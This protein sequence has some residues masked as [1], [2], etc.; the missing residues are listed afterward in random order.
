MPEFIRIDR[1]GAV[2]VVT[3]DRPAVLN[4]WH[5]AMRAEVSVALEAAEADASVRA[6]VLTG[7]GERAFCAGQDLAEAQHFA[8]EHAAGWI[9]EWARL[10]GAMR[11]L[12][13]PSLVALNG[14]AAG[15]GFQFALL[16]DVRVGHPGVRMGQ[17]E[18]DAG[19]PSITGPWIMQLALGHSRTVEL[20]LSARLMDGEEA[21]RLGLIHHLVPA[22]AVMG[23]AME[24]AQ[25]LAAK[26]PLAMRLTKQRFR[27]VTEAGFREALAAA[28]LYHAEGYASGEPARVMAAFLARRNARGGKGTS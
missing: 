16:A 13:K 26:P 22:E 24:V 5:R 20:A 14:V 18:I 25:A 19:I 4:A 7:A 1:D 9:E 17:T 27:E 28:A 21:A 11:A 23:K 8:G 10:Y 3:L 15:S 2:A 6:V 12:S